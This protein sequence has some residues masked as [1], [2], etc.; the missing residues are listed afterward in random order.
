MINNN[1]QNS[2]FYVMMYLVKE[3]SYNIKG[4]PNI[5][6]LGEPYFGLIT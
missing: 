1:L 6:V 2:Q 5:R 3:T 4:T